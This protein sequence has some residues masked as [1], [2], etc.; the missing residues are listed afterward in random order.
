MM[1]NFNPHF[2]KNILK[3]CFPF[4]LI[5]NCIIKYKM[6]DLVGGS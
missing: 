6:H 2:I 3:K 4:L 5:H 1:E